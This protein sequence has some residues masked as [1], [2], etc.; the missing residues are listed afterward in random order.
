[1]KTNEYTYQDCIDHLKRSRKNIELEGKAILKRRGLPEYL[2]KDMLR[3]PYFTSMEHGRIED[4]FYNFIS[5]MSN[6]IMDS[7]CDLC[8]V[9]ELHNTERLLMSQRI[10]LQD[11]ELQLEQL[12]RR[13]HQP[14]VIYVVW[15]SKGGQIKLKRK[16]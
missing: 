1:M 12:Q 8:K 6:M 7:I 2:Y 16:K 14:C 9:P 4:E 5:I 3:I 13:N 15:K 11:M 10:K